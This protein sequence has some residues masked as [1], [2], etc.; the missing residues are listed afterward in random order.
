MLGIILGMRYDKSTTVCPSTR[1]ILPVVLPVAGVVP[2]FGDIETLSL[3]TRQL[4][5]ALLGLDI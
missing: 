1:G 5:L 4:A 2:L 3:N